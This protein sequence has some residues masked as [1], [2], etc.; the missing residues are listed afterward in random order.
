VKKGMFITLVIILTGVCVLLFNSFYKEAK[1]VAITMLNEEQMIHA[2]QAERGI[3]DFFATWTRNLNTLAKMDEI[4]ENSKVG[5]HYMKLFYEAN[6]EQI[7]SITRLDE[8]GVI[9]YNFPSGDSVGTDISDQKHVRELL[10]DHK[11]VVSDV[12]KAVEGFESVALHVPIFRGSVFKGSVGIL[13]DF[14]GL[15]NR[16]LDVIKIGKT[17][18]AWVV[19]RDGTQLYS[20]IPGF[21]GKSVFENIKG[22]PQL[23]VM[24]ED[25]LKGHEGVG[26]FIFDRIGDRNV[27]QIRKYAVYRPVQ[28]GNTF[29]SIVVNSAEEDVLSGLIS[30]RNKLIFVIG[31]IFIF[32]IALSALGAKAWFVVKEEEKRKLIENQLHESEERLSLAAESANVGL[33]SWDFDTGQIWATEKV[34]EAY[35]FSPDE[36]LTFDKLLAVIHPDDRY[37]WN[38]GAQHALREGTYYRSEYR[39]VLP[40]SSLRWVKVQAQSFLKRSGEPDRM[41]GVSLDITAHKEMEEKLKAASEEWQTTFDSIPDLIMILD[42]DCKVLRVNA[43]TNVFLDIPVE[44]IIGSKCHTLMH[45]PKEQVEG[46]PFEKMVQ[47]KKHEDT[48]FYDE[49]RHAWFHVSVDPIFNNEGEVRQVIHSTRN[50]TEQKRVEIEVFTARRGLMQRE[51]LMHMGELTA[52][53]A[54]ELNQP[55]MSILANARAA[56]RFMESGTLDMGELKEILEDIASDDKRAGDIIRS[57]RA[58]LKPGESELESIVLND[59]LRDTIH[60][61]HSEAII[62][63]IKIEEDFVETLQ[64]VNV[65]KVQIQQV[66]INL[67]LNASE[68]MSESMGNRKII[69]R[70]RISDNNR[71]EVSFRDFGIGI[72]KNAMENIFDPFYTTKRSGLGIGLSLSRSIIESHGGHIR[73][74]NNPD[75]GATFYFDLPLVSSK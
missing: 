56:L 25:M 55:L 9:L 24:V 7:K 3:E 66:V 62:R 43:A 47:S 17:G 35:G 73:C 72:G 8:R 37:L 11:P 31:A 28:I 63:I 67:L 21:T 44:E 49:I 46:C 19:S 33:W 50:V 41:M 18:Y 54:H 22:F 48:E 51:R 36:M 14:K 74:E 59:L 68:S 69:I 71:I 10:R 5:K 38:Q 26:T 34:F 42:K 61:F 29:W 6:Q 12:F 1:N 23:I 16:Y 60:L 13:I 70:T 65:D 27:G 39:V 32:G 64:R 57:L 2:K 40:D 20:P 15:A 4:I 30:F 75:E 52:S 53:V 45:W 58:M